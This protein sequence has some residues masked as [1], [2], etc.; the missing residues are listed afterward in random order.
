M[1]SSSIRFFLASA[2][3][4]SLVTITA[5][6]MAYDHIAWAEYFISDA[7]VNTPGTGCTIDWDAMDGQTRVGAG[8]V[9]AVLSKA[10]GW[11]PSDV[12]AHW[13]VFCPASPTLYTAIGN[14]TYFT[15]ITNVADVLEDDLFVINSTEVYGGHTMMVYTPPVEVLHP[16]NPIVAGTTQWT[17]KVLDS[18]T[19]AHGCTDTRWNGYCY[20]FYGETIPGAGEGR[21]RIYSDTATGALLGYTWSFTPSS[22]S[23]YSPETRPF[24]IGRLTGLMPPASE[25]P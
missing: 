1:L 5:P 4:G 7:A 3:A 8:F 23:Y 20:P 24:R 25:S 10:M 15:Q 16:V 6:A 13:G 21:V 19:T 14:G 17:M 22:T 9:I 18:T 11:Q 2:A 12:E